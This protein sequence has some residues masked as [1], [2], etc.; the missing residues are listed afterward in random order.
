MS[1]YSTR[2]YGHPAAVLLLR[3]CQAQHVALLATLTLVVGC[4]GSGIGGIKRNDASAA[5]AKAI[6]LYDRNADGKLAAD[7]LQNAPALAA[8]GR[9]I[10]SDGDGAITR[11]EIQAR[12]ETVR[13]GAGYFGFDVRLM[14]KSKALAGATITLTPEPFNGDGFPTF[15]ATTVE[16]GAGSLQSDGKQL[17]GVPAGFYQAKIVHASQGI[18]ATRGV[19]VSDETASRGIEIAL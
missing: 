11:Q 13:A 9:R 18:D 1:F 16:G 19:E 10:D 6:E 15:T 7:E 12:I 14:S 4:G 3:Q 8:N 2:G 5:A 17:P